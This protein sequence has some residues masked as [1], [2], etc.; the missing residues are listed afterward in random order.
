MRILIATLLATAALTGTAEAA[1][2]AWT[3]CDGGF[4]CAT[5]Q[6][7]LDYAKPAGAKVELALIRLPAS[8]PAHRIG[9]LFTNPGDHQLITVQLGLAI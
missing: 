8:D 5:A 3:D 1:P 9:T 4:Q 6:V 2:L 7:P